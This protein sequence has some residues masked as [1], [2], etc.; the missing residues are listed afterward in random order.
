MLHGRSSDLLNFVKKKKVALQTSWISVFPQIH[1]LGLRKTSS[2]FASL[3]P[4]AGSCM[5]SH[6]RRGQNYF[7][8]RMDLLHIPRCYSDKTML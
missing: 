4:L 6:L 3:V 2:I 1:S 7:R 5:Y 8:K